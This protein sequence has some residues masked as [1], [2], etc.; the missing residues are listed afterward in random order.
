VISVLIT[1]VHNEHIKELVKLKEK[2]YRDESNAFLVETKHLALEAYNCRYI[3]GYSET[4]LY[5]KI[6]TD[7]TLVKDFKEIANCYTLYKEVLSNVGGDFSNS[8]GMSDFIFY[9]IMK[10]KNY[11]IDYNCYK[12]IKQNK[13]LSLICKK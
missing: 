10:H 7:E 3:L 12:K 11:K 13:I 2:K 1:S 4:Y 9:I 6:P 8:R 5:D